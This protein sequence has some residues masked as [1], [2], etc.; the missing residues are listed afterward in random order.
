MQ[1]HQFHP[2]VA[3]G[4][5]ISNQ[6]L[7]LQ[8]LLRDMGYRSEIFCEQLPIQFEGERSRSGATLVIPPLEMFYFFTSPWA[9]PPTSS[10]G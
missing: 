2:T 5:A 10:P 9:I 1:V 3:Y 8:D 7:S 4:D 6:I